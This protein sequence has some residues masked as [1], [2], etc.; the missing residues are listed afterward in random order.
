M[1]VMFV[2]QIF[3]TCVNA[4]V[5]FPSGEHPLGEKIA[6]AHY[7]SEQQSNNFQNASDDVAGA[8]EED[9]E[10]EHANH[11]HLS[12]FPPVDNNLI[13][14]IVISDII[15]NKHINYPDYNYAPPIPPPSI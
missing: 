12:C 10:H 15:T 4:S 2:C 8:S 13:S 11:S 14:N 5:H 9:T 1:L 6:H 7:H 3:A